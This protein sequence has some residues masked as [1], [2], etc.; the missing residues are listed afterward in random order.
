MLMGGRETGRASGRMTS[1]PKLNFA[2]A[3]GLGSDAGK[4]V[5]GGS[6]WDDTPAG[7][8]T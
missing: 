4:S 6:S 1:A 8:L 2:G 3:G 7:R 5:R